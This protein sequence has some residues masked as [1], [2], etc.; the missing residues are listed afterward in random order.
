MTSINYTSPSMPFQLSSKKKQK[1]QMLINQ[2]VCGY[3]ANDH[4]AAVS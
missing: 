4:K 1:K 2:I 3:S